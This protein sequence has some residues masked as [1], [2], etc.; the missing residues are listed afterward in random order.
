MDTIMCWLLTRYDYSFN[1]WVMKGLQR[2]CLQPS[3]KKTQF[4]HFMGFPFCWWN[5]LTLF[6]TWAWIVAMKYLL[7]QQIMSK[8]GLLVGFVKQ[9]I[10][11]ERHLTSLLAIIAVLIILCCLSI[12]S[13]VCGG[14]TIVPC[15][16]KPIN[17]KISCKSSL[18]ESF[19]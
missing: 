10:Q 17:F 4:Q 7:W 9:A 13:L 15:V 6:Q 16:W 3:E 2:F 11:L 12:N 8:L 18:S 1:S 14:H 5:P 19:C